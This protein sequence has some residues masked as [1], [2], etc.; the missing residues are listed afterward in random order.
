MAVLHNAVVSGNGSASFTGSFVVDLFTHMVTAP[1]YTY[2]GNEDTDSLFKAGYVALG[3]NFTVPV[4]AVAR[5]YWYDKQWLNW[6]D[7]GWSVP[8][9]GNGIFANRVR[10]RLAAG[11][12]VR[13][14][15]AN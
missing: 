14:Y 15:I 1:N 13:L 4:D 6:T 5:V 9:M 2:R 8:Q 11:L 10:W 3:N 7:W 12:S